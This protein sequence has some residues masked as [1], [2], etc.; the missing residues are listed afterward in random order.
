MPPRVNRWDGVIFDLDNTLFPSRSVPPEVLAP[1]LHAVRAAN[2]GAGAITEERLAAA[3]D[4]CW[5]DSFDAVAARFDLPSVLRA[6][7][8]EAQRRLVVATR[9]TPYADTVPALTALMLPR[10]LVTTGYRL[11]QESKV[12]ALGLVPLFESVHIDALDEAPR[13]GKEEI[14]RR[15][16]AASSWSPERVV[17]VG[18]NAVSEIAAGNRLGMLT[19]QVLRPGVVR[20][21]SARHRIADL[22]ELEPLLRGRPAG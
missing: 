2:A 11:L 21:A 18:D 14:F 1:A 19:V 17:V 12:A 3:L 8:H 16:V 15:I 9:L 13:L 22:S 20:T 4:A 5:T 10:V 6:A 7:W